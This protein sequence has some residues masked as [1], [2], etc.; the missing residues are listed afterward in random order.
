MAT[1]GTRS[2]EAAAAARRPA[3]PGAPVRT[4]P[5]PPRAPTPAPSGGPARSGAAP[6]SA[7]PAR[8]GAAPA[9][10]HDAFWQPFLDRVRAE[11]L[12]VYMMLVAGRP[13]GLDDEV[14]RIGIDSETMR[15]DASRREVIDLL[16]TAAGAVAGRPLRVEIGPLPPEH[17]DDTAI[18][19]GRKRTEDT[20]ADPMVQAAVEIF[21]GEVRGV[22]ERRPRG[23]E[24]P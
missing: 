23:G 22:R 4:A 7:P 8:A 15:R 6:S 1:S 19:R 9:G 18:A 20:L 13:V 10:T 14:L 21:G 2:P 17:A 24:T 11:R 5:P 3:G 12:A 16:Q